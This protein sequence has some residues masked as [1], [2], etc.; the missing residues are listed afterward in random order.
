MIDEPRIV[1]GLKLPPKRIIHTR[2]VGGRTSEAGKP[3]ASGFDF[4]NN[5]NLMELSYKKRRG[6][7]WS[8][9]GRATRREWWLTFATAFLGDLVGGGLMIL[10]GGLIFFAVAEVSLPLIGLGAVICLLSFAMQIPVAVRRVHDRGLGGW[11]V[12]LFYAGLLI[13]YV[14]VAVALVMLIVL[15]FLDG[16]F[17]ENEYGPDPRGRIGYNPP[18]R[19]I[20]GVRPN[21]QAIG[22][23]A[24][25]TVNVSDQNKS[26]PK[27]SLVE[28]LE[29][30]GSLK[31]R[32]LL[33]DEEFE[34]Q[35]KKI[36][37]Q[38]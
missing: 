23:S 34:L 37:E 1:N 24:N 4:H 12:I 15:G 7:F 33:T 8:F 2:K 17:G 36:L 19:L 6:A 10:G 11:I 13:P 29:K 18:K 35:K 5:E 27:D 31:E 38:M 20:G 32:G 28:R 16:D 25:V 22:G 3:R 14:D 21:V 26:P 30:L 9:N